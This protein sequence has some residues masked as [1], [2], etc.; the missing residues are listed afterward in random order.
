M[1][2]MKYVRASS[3]LI[4]FKE[5]FLKCFELLDC[6]VFRCFFFL[7]FLTLDLSSLQ[8]QVR[9]IIHQP[10]KLLRYEFFRIVIPHPSF[11]GSLR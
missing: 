9:N 3:G 2:I 5:L 10:S 6:H 4:E 8:A 1:K 7:G 11:Q